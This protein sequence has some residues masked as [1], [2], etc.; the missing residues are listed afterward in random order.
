MARGN[1]SVVMGGWGEAASQKSSRCKGPEVR[2][3]QG[4][5]SWKET[6]VEQWNAEGETCLFAFPPFC[7]APC[8]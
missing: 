1:L 4:L 2:V 3:A 7:P 6:R 5:R 8:T